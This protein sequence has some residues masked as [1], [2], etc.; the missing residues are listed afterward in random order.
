M[1]EKVTPIKEDPRKEEVD[2]V[3]PAV[4]HK[5]EFLNMVIVMANADILTIESG[6]EMAKR[7]YMIADHFHDGTSTKMLANCSV[8]D[9]MNSISTQL[10]HLPEI[11][12]IQF[13]MQNLLEIT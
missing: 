5:L 13:L 6:G 9:M 10:H 11:A 2:L 12:R 8:N 1:T 3:E 7:S 4:E